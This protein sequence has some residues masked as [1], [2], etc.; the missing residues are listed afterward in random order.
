MKLS[1][2]VEPIHAILCKCCE[3]RN[4]PQDMRDEKKSHSV[5][6]QEKGAGEGGG[7]R[8]QQLRWHLSSR[9]PSIW[10]GDLGNKSTPGIQTRVLSYMRSL[11][12]VLGIKWQER[13]TNTQVMEK[14]V[15][16]S[17]LLQQCKHVFVVLF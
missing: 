7:I 13:V 10:V 8:L 15:V 11:R 5:G 16:L 17:I 4:V 14:T 9:C 2:L 3:E 12:R 6:P 1:S